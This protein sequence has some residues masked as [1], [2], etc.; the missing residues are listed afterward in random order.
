MSKKV[1]C[2]DCESANWTGSLYC[3][4]CGANL[5]KSEYKQKS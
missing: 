3:K 4:K 1:I 2:S 5:F